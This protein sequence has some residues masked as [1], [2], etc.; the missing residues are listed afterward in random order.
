[1]WKICVKL[2]IICVHFVKQ[3]KRSVHCDK[4]SEARSP[5]GG[6]SRARSHA[7]TAQALITMDMCK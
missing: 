1:M 4:I 2:I 6:H 7:Y 5:H 3:D